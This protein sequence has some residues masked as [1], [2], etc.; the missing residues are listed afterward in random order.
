MV[1]LYTFLTLII[2]II[3]AFLW[4]AVYLYRKAINLAPYYAE[5]SSLKKDIEVAHQTIS[6]KKEE[7]DNLSGKLAEAKQTIAE[8]EVARKFLSENAGKVESL[9][10]QIAQ[11]QAELDNV[12]K[13][14]QDKVD[15]LQ[16]K[17]KELLKAQ[18]DL[19]S[20]HWLCQTEENKKK[21]IEEEC[22]RLEADLKALKSKITENEAIKKKQEEE[23][24]KLNIRN[25]ELT[26]TIGDKELRLSN[27]KDDIVKKQSEIDRLQKEAELRLSNIK[28]DIVRLQKEIEE[29]KNTRKVLTAEVSELEVQ[30]NRYNGVKIA[31]EKK[32]EDLDREIKTIPSASCKYVEYEWLEEFVDKLQ[33][34]HLKFSSRLVRAFHTSLKVADSSPLVVLAGISGTGK[35]LLPELYAHAIGM[36]FLQI[37]VQPRWDSPQDLLGFYNYMEGRFKATELSR[38]LWQTDLYNNRERALKNPAMNLILLDEMN[39]ARV[40]YYFS[41]L[42]SKLEVRRGLNANNT[43]ARNAA[44]IVLEAGSHGAV[45][46]IRRIFVGHNNLFVG[47]MNEDESTQTLSDKVKDRANILRFGRPHELKG[48]KANKEGFFR[49]YSESNRMMSLDMWKKS[50]NEANNM[51]GV[52]LEGIL[53]SFNEHLA[54]LGRPFGHRMWNAVGAYVSQYPGS[55]HDALIDQIEMKI[56]PKLTG[57]DMAESTIATAIGKLGNYIATLKDEELSKAYKEASEREFFTWMGIDRAVK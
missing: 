8:A 46:D 51:G 37:P 11:T 20:C 55:K 22:S 10:V 52:D 35:S 56:L 6:A 24:A 18:S 40:E 45:D 14:Y 39:L 15:E 5:L 26:E 30:I 27:I 49:A 9:K 54:V 13:K 19:N 28:D 57:L 31:Q 53:N 23:V 7:L 1:T 47:T 4:A 2:V 33:S 12:T 32:W 21:H 36:N 25:R 3:L 29:L 48:T 41:E 16:Q 42:L 50:F 17:N 34:N 44:E 38:L 43:V